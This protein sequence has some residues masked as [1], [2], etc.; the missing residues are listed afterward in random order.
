MACVG[1]YVTF[2]LNVKY[3]ALLIIRKF[4]SRFFFF[5][6]FLFPIQDAKRMKNASFVKYSKSGGKF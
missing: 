4:F 1:F 5:I 2:T 6:P 3:D